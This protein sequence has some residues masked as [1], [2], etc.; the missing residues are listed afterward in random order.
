MEKCSR[1]TLIII[2]I[3]IIIIIKINKSQQ[4]HQTLSKRKENF[5]R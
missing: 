5:V 2:I 1:N 3:I 4:C